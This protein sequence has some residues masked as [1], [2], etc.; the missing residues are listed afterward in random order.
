VRQLDEGLAG[1]G[2]AVSNLILPIGDIANNYDPNPMIVRHGRGPE[3]KTCRTC[4]H[5]VATSP[6]GN[7]TYWKCDRRGMSRSTA[8]DHR[9][10][11][12]ACR[13]YE[14]AP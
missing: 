8:T 13:L 7:K 1:G 4:V 3:G 6:T 5:A 11:W 2:D 9:L 12:N 14:A 10:K